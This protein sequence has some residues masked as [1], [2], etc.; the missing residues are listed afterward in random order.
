MPL[1]ARGGSPRVISARSALAKRDT[2]L[3]KDEEYLRRREAAR[4]KMSNQVASRRSASLGRDDVGGHSPSLGRS[5]LAPDDDWRTR[6]AQVHSAF[7]AAHQEAAPPPDDRDGWAPVHAK[8][9]PAEGDEHIMAAAAR[10]QAEK[11]EAKAAAMAFIEQPAQQKTLKKMAATKQ[12]LRRKEAAL[13][14]LELRASRAPGS[15]ASTAAAKQLETLQK[16]VAA[17][18]ATHSAEL[19]ALAGSDAR[20]RRLGVPHDAAAAAVAEAAP[21][22]AAAAPSAPQSAP[23][24]PPAARPASAPVAKP[25]AAV[26]PQKSPATRARLSARELAAEE[27]RQA[28]QAAQRAAWREQAQKLA[29][30]KQGARSRSQTSLEP[31]VAQA[32]D[33]A[34]AERELRREEDRVQMARL[35]GELAGLVQRA[36]P[37]TEAHLDGPTIEMREDAKHLNVELAIQ[38]RSAWSAA[39]AGLQ[40]VVATAAPRTSTWLDED[41]DPRVEYGMDARPLH[42]MREVDW[43]QTQSWNGSIV[44]SPPSRPWR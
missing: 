41:C 26:P 11:Q 7:F 38:R 22:V 27:T 32:L 16:E 37:R 15:A 12:S 40:R 6:R 13:R 9:R 4:I 33:A 17:L 43:R 18:Q 23:R 36:A 1:A 25:K 8:V 20:E 19:A 10:R 29:A 28:K 5:R 14:A 2:V 24:K 3:S 39:E 21:S 34:A 44:G 35:E 31:R 42:E 30:M